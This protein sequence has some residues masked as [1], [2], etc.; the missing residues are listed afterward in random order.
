MLKFSK[1]ATVSVLVD[2]KWISNFVSKNG[3]KPEIITQLEEAGVNILTVRNLH[4]KIALL[5]AGKEE[6]L[7]V[8]SS[9][10]TK[11]AMYLS[12]EA[13]IYIL[14]DDSG[15]FKELDYYITE[16]F[17]SAQPILE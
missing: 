16:L 4:A 6:T 8:G 12:H 15:T 5:K 3:E 1:N 11:T 17:K 14:N 10:F 13:G 7:L 9:N 2:R